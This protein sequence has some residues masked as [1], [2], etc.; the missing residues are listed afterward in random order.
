MQH[1][2][3][4][5]SLAEVG[6]IEQELP[7]YMYRLNGRAI[8]EIHP[9]RNVMEHNVPNFSQVE[10]GTVHPIQKYLHGL[11]GLAISEMHT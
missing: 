3:P 1:N 2:V 7:Y 8:S 10:V 9:W 5:F 11:N 6:A 4:Y